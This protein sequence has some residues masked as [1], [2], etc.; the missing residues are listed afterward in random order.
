MESPRF[1]LF[2]EKNRERK[3][4]KRR[5]ALFIAFCCCIV[6]PR[7]H[8][9]LNTKF[10]FCTMQNL[11]CKVVSCWSWPLFVGLFFHGYDTGVVTSQ[12][13]QPI[14]FEDISQ[15]SREETQTLKPEPKRRW[16]RLCRLRRRWKQ[17]TFLH[18]VSYDALRVPGILKN[19]CVCIVMR[20]EPGMLCPA[21]LS[22]GH[23]QVAHSTAS[24]NQAWFSLRN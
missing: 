9:V 14:V 11:G 22:S 10:L 6:H 3:K 4:K 23:L 5:S 21:P 19:T 1:F 2:E 20:V 17:S 15:L 12:S 13:Q 16:R 18:I 7:Y 24:Q 8:A